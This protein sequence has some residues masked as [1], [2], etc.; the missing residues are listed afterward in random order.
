MI[1]DSFPEHKLGRALALYS[2]G[3]PVVRALAGVLGRWAVQAI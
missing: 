1:A 2:I 3:I